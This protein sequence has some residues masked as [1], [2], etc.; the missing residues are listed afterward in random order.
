M[1]LDEMQADIDFLLLRSGRAGSCSFTSD[2]WTGMSSNALVSLAYGGKQDAMPHDRSDYAAC[3]RTVRRLPKH[4]RTPEVLDGLRRA[5]AAYLGNYP[6]DASS[7][8]RRARRQE[9]EEEKRKRDEREKEYFRRRTK[10]K[11]GT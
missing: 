5:R 9:W 4:R 6:E 11:Y 3:V 10:R 1:T 7:L 2:R 8:V